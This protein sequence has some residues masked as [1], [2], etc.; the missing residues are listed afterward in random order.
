MEVADV[1]RS[2][3]QSCTLQPA[4]EDSTSPSSSSYAQR[5]LDVL[6][7]MVGSR[8]LT[9]F[10]GR[11]RLAHECVTCCVSILF[12]VQPNLQLSGKVLTL[13]QHLAKDPQLLQWLR[14]EFE[15]HSALA[16]FFQNRAIEDNVPMQLQVIQLLRDLCYRHQ[17]TLT[18]SK[19]GY[20]GD[21]LFK[22]MESGND[23]LFLPC[24]ELLNHLSWSAY[25]QQYMKIMPQLPQL[26]RALVPMT[27]FDNS[28]V[29]MH[30]LAIFANLSL[31]EF[32]SN[33]MF[34]QSMKQTLQVLLCTV[35]ASNLAARKIAT[36]IIEDLLNHQERRACVLK[37]HKM[38][39]S[40]A[41]KLAEKKAQ[42]E[43]E[44]LR[45][46]INLLTVILSVPELL[47][48][49]VGRTPSTLEALLSLLV[50]AVETNASSLDVAHMSVKL[51]TLLT[52]E[53]CT[54]NLLVAHNA[55]VT[56][57]LK[58][59]TVL[60]VAL[61]DKEVDSLYFAPEMY[62]ASLRFFHTLTDSGIC[63]ETIVKQ[64][65]TVEHI[66][67]LLKPYLAKDPHCLQDACIAK[68]VEVVTTCLDFLRQF[69]TKLENA[70]ECLQELLQKPVTASYLSL[71]LCLTMED[72]V[73]PAFH[74]TIMANFQQD[75][76][77][78]KFVE[79]LVS[80]NR[81]RKA[82]ESPAKRDKPPP[83]MHA[84]G[85]LP[86]PSI[87]VN[88]HNR[89]LSVENSIERI[90]R[91]LEQSFEMGELKQSEILAV[92]ENKI[93]KLKA[94]EEELLQL[95]EAK[96][97]ALQQSD[98]LV[99][100]YTCIEAKNEAEVEELR[101]LLRA[102]ERRIEDTEERMVEVEKRSEE[103]AQSLKASRTKVKALKAHI[104]ELEQRNN[105]LDVKAKRLEVVLKSLESAQ[106]EIQSQKEMIA[107]LQKHGDSMKLKLEA[108]TKANEELE[109]AN[110]DQEKLLKEHEAKMKDQAKCLHK[111]QGSLDEKTALVK[112]LKAELKS[113]N[114]ASIALQKENSALEQQLQALESK[115]QKKDEALQS[116]SNQVAK[117]TADLDKLK[118]MQEMIQSISAGIL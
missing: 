11:G 22:R 33:K 57:F 39:V 118:K 58:A 28:C 3:V 85:T 14:D 95:L 64:C 94:R 51:V 92:Y 104:E 19:L 49:Y 27:T 69:M 15:L 60:L 114:E 53:M 77:R 70:E 83:P 23:E 66:R 32:I 46:T 76:S 90:S 108:L 13:F 107:M 1:A 99:T 50:G 7:G 24:L 8:D 73:M 29:V 71:A 113:I 89:R 109:L 79:S 87:P 35:V 59:V 78:E 102:S 63:G 2:F 117:L 97:A 34:S 96:T 42:R 47:E 4:H 18:E 16:E 101:S 100:K 112:S 74:L 25:A 116:K 38:M 88:N 62:L 5:Q 10:A 91:K 80:V 61:Q 86:R 82:L 111:L 105:G 84:A 65:L 37:Y 21:F 9:F 68:Q 40:C 30:T 48:G 115:Y 45:T 44:D 41:S 93:F 36:D 110:Q 72:V 12:E 81:K 17:V 56:A 20:L 31:D 98:R 75:F 52:K 26:C 54:Q 67:A 103:T 55:P 6:N 106:Q 43:P